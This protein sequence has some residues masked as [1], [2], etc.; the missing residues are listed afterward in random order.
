M[1]GDA[2]PHHASTQHCDFFDCF[3]AH[4]LRPPALMQSTV[5]GRWQCARTYRRTKPLALLRNAMTA[6]QYLRFKRAELVPLGLAAALL[7]GAD[8]SHADVAAAIK[9]QP[10]RADIVPA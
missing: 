1:C 6:A 10:R 2:R 8:Q 3:C 7:H 5:A 4:R 9:W